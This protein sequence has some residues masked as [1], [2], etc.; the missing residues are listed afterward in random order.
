[1]SK[2]RPGRPTLVRLRLNPHFVTAV[3]ACRLPYE[4]LSL[5]CGCSGTHFSYLINT[6]GIPGSPKNIDVMLRTADAIK[7]PRAQVF[8]DE[9]TIAETQVTSE[10]VQR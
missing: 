3:R 7:F 2:G 8:L 9:P 1:M 10:A 6:V 4:P 5:A